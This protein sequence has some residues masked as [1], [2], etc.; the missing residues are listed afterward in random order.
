MLQATDPTYRLKP[1]TYVVPEPARHLLRAARFFRLLLGAA[2]TDPLV[3]GSSP[4]GR[5]QIGPQTVPILAGHCG[6]TLPRL[7]PLTQA[8]THTARCWWSDPPHPRDL[9]PWHQWTGVP[10]G[11]FAPHT[12]VDQVAVHQ[13]WR[14]SNDRS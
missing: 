5:D 1:V 14:L 7:H 12:D 10:V 11:A 13:S 2:Q 9:H 8:W 3:A 6:I 4:L